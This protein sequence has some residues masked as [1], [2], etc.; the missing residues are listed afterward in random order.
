MRAVELRLRTDAI[1]TAQAADALDRLIYAW[2]GDGRELALRLRVAELRIAS[3][4]WRRALALLR[5][6]ADGPAADSWPDQVAT[7]RARMRADFAAALDADAHAPLPPFDFVALIDDNPDLLPD[8]AAGQALAE[9]IADR[10]A[11]LDL[12]DR[13]A[14]L[15]RKLVDGTPAGPA[16]AEIGA[17]LAALRLGAGDAAGALAALSDS[18]ATDLPAEL[19]ERRTIVFAR[20]T[21]ARGSLAPAVAA[22]AALDTPAATEVRASL[23]EAAKDWPAAEAALAD[24]VRLTVPAEG[25]LDEAAGRAVLRL[26]AAA[27][28]AGDET[29]LAQLRDD[30]LPRLP[31]GKLADML[32]VLTERPV[33]GVG[34]LPRAAQETALARALPADLHALGWQAVAPR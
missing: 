25:A 8:G 24:Y 34:D 7:V 31:A 22:L 23:L 30:T 12:P 26:A 19:Q 5:E 18:A 10:L 20:A 11:A 4:A 16:R 28:Q 33:A 2:R 3:G 27:A 1:T 21:A 29:M 9:R 14:T 13:A 32:R 6:T 17:R 15:L